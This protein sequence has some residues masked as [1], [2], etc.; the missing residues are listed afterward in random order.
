M[1]LPFSEMRS[2]LKRRIKFISKNAMIKRIDSRILV[3][4]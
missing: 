1:F 3:G 4:V 2:I